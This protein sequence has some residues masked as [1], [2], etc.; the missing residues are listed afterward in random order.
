VDTVKIVR[1]RRGDEREG[2]DRDGQA[3]FA[4]GQ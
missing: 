3:Y 4:D 1:E 2:K